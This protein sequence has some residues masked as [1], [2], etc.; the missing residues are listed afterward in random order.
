MYLFG[1]HCS[2]REDVHRRL[3]QCESSYNNQFVVLKVDYHISLV[4]Q[5]SSFLYDQ[6]IFC[7]LRITAEMEEIKKKITFSF[8]R[9]LNVDHLLL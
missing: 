4:S 6:E 7:R 1:K 2:C 9:Y 5:T 3:C 8:G